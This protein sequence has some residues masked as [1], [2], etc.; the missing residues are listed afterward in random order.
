MV[1]DI[2]SIFFLSGHHLLFEKRNTHTLFEIANYNEIVKKNA[3]VPDIALVNRIRNSNFDYMVGLKD[4]I[5]RQFFIFLKTY[6][7]FSVDFQDLNRMDFV[8]LLIH[9]ILKKFCTIL[10]LKKF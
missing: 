4:S 5:Y 10:F 9:H 7:T 8:S 3:P 6:V 1:Q 2:A